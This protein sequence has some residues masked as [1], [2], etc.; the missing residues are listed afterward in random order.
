MASIIEKLEP[1]HIPFRVRTSAS[2]IGEQMQVWRKLNRITSAQ[3]AERAG[4]SRSVVTKIENG[5]ASVSFTNFLRVAHVLG[6][7]DRLEDATDPYQ[8]DFGR[9][10]ADQALPQRVRT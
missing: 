2:D 7:L 6:L 10:R 3:L 4:V 1:K 9:V 5:D 8:T